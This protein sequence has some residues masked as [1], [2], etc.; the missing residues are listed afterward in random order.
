MQGMRLDTYLIPLAK[1]NCKW[2]E[3]LKVRP[4]AIKLLE[5]NTGE[6]SP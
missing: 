2:I 4:E 5:E 1:I 3:D 6:K